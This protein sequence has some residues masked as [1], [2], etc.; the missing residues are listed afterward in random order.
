MKA[1]VRE[2]PFL[3]GGF[4]GQQ[5][6]R[7]LACIG[8][9]RDGGNQ[10]LEKLQQTLPSNGRSL[11]LANV[12][13]LDLLQQVGSGAGGTRLK[14]I[15]GQRRHRANHPQHLPISLDGGR[16]QN[17]CSAILDFF[18]DDI[19]GT[20]ERDGAV[21]ADRRRCS[22]RSDWIPGNIQE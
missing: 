17:L 9:C 16:P 14:L 15:V 1:S 22:V 2:W 12:Q 20:Q 11:D 19:G 4:V 10:A 3:A 21:G 18:K 5:R 13:P 6:N 7:R 8:R